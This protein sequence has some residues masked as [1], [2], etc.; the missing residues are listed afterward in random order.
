M[1]FVGEVSS[2]M[3][4]WKRSLVENGFPLFVLVKKS[5]P[6]AAL[7]KICP[8]LQPSWNATCGFIQAIWLLCILEISPGLLAFTILE[9][10]QTIHSPTAIFTFDSWV[11]INLAPV[12]AII[13]GRRTLFKTEICKSVSWWGLRWNRKVTSQLFRMKS[14]GSNPLKA[15]FFTNLFATKNQWSLLWLRFTFFNLW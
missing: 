15:Y 8:P 5:I 1:N 4:C 2:F 3:R 6:L 13:K 12:R 14:M 10:T 9:S 7:S 11:I